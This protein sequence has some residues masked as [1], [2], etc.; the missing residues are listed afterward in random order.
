MGKMG[1]MEI[2]ISALTGTFKGIRLKQITPSMLKTKEELNDFITVVNL[3]NAEVLDDHD[4]VML[5]RKYLSEIG[6]TKFQ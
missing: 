4:G 2:E 6:I 5:A 3:H 1:K